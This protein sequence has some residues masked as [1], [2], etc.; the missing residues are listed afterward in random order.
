MGKAT[1]FMEYERMDGPVVAQKDRVKN[2]EEFHGAL[3]KHEQCL[4]AA[5]CMDCGVPFCQAGVKLDGLVSAGGL[6]EMR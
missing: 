5:R 1:G 2:F 3:P 6:S 4:Q